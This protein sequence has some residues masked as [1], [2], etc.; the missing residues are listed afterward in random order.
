MTLSARAQLHECPSQ[1]ASGAGR[2]R[3]LLQALPEVQ[4]LEKNVA[5]PLSQQDH[6]SPRELP[7]PW[8]MGLEGNVFLPG[9]KPTDCRFMGEKEKGR[10]ASHGAHMALTRV[11]GDIS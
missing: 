5:S 4:G 1:E 9:E 7:L 6:E 3:G 10:G 11:T 2:A 8:W